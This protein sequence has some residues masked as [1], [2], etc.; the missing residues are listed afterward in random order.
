MA[1]AMAASANSIAS[2]KFSFTNGNNANGWPGGQGPLFEK[3]EIV[4]KGAYGAVYRGVNRQTGQVVAL[5]VSWAQGCGTAGQP[6][7]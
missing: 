1:M 2:N 6:M 7:Y 4:G 5:K 3:H